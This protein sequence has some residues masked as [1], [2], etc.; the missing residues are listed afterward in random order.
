MLMAATVLAMTFNRRKLRRL[1]IT[2]QPHPFGS[3]L[4]RH[5][6]DGELVKML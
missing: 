3:A 4:R 1:K 5:V 6:T 2:C